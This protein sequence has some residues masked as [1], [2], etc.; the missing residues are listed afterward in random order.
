MFSKPHVDTLHAYD[1][2]KTHLREYLLLTSHLQ[3]K[4][5]SFPLLLNFVF[6]FFF[7]FFLSPSH[8][9]ILKG[10]G[11]LDEHV[12]NVLHLT[13]N[14]PFEENYY[15]TTTTTKKDLF[16][17]TKMNEAAAAKLRYQ[18]GN[19]KGVISSCSNGT[20][21]WISQLSKQQAM[22]LQQ[23]KKINPFFISKSFFV[24]VC[25]SYFFFPSSHMYPFVF[26]FFIFLFLL[27]FLDFV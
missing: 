27:I 11:I 8:I 4:A 12:G 16:W 24:F 22:K 10:T 3:F 6:T 17:K 20:E 26:A 5:I 7:F 2:R 21:H 1:E 13:I 25:L 19:E 15:T 14:S 23:V 9:A 18:Q